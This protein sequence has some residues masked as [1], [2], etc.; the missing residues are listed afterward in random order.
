MPAAQPV[1]DLLLAGM[2][3]SHTIVRT[4]CDHTV[5][6]LA[7][8]DLH[9]A[10]Q[11]WILASLAM[12]ATTVAIIFLQWPS[13][14]SAVMTDLQAAECSQWRE[15]A[16]E[17]V[18]DAFPMTGD[19][20]FALRTLMVKDRVVLSSVSSYDEHRLKVG[21]KRAVKS[22][23]TWALVMGIFYAAGWV[24]ARTAAKFRKLK[25]QKSE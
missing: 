14:D 9:A 11:F 22:L 12:L 4:D 1:C 15:I 2:A 10:Q 5:A 23:L 20:C 17:R 25:T 13:R 8:K 24:S 6:E 18:Y 21:I 7:I 19:A 3:D 16:P